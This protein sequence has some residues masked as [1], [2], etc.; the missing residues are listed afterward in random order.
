MRLFRFISER[1]FNSIMSG[2][3]IHSE[4]DWSLKYDTNSKGICFFANN[5]TDKIDRIVETALDDWGF[6]GIVKEYAVIEIETE[7]ARK[8]WGFYSGGRRTEYNLTDYDLTMVK[9]VY[10]IPHKTFKSFSGEYRAIR[11]WEKPV[12]LVYSK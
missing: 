6:S 4:R 9:A 7:T 1:E 2:E 3:R 5:R 11:D 8:A 12:T 10:T